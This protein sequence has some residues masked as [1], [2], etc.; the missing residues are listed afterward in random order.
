MTFPAFTVVD[1]GRSAG[2]RQTLPADERAGHN[3]P[4]APM[5][6]S[7]QPGGDGGSARG[8]RLVIQ[9]APAEGLASDVAPLHVHHVD[10][11]AWHVI[12]GALRFRFAAKRSS[13]VLVPL[14]SCPRRGTCLRD[15]R[16]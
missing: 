15:R 13:R 7:A 2:L 4:P 3:M 14:C 9:A 5:I 8:S 12:A 1:P 16:A 11:E 6:I 10:D